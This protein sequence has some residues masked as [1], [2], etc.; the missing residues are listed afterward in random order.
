LW[1]DEKRETVMGDIGRLARGLAAAVLA[2]VLAGSAVAQD[3]FR[4]IDGSLTYRERIALPPDAFAVV[5]A[6][7]TRGRL[8]G[9]ATLRTRGAQVPLPFQIAVPQGMEAELRAAV[10]VDG[11]PAWYAA[12]IAVSAGSDPLSLGELVLC[13]SFRWASPDRSAVAAASSP[14]G[15]TR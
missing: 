3:G 13:A 9:E 12:G 4:M 11:R 5:E 7:D 10:V 14:S 2:V 15:S 1:D 6:R 8:L